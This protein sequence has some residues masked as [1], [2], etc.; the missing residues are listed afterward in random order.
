MTGIARLRELAEQIDAATPP[1]RDRAVDALRALAIVG[2]IFGHWLVT[3]LVVLNDGHGS[4]VH[5]ASPLATLP[6]LTPASWCS[7]RSRS[8]SWSEGTRRQR[9]FAVTIAAG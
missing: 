1:H 4:S 2:V 7:R 5:D 3:A 6:I 8:S 9:A